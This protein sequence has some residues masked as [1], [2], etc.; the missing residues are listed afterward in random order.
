MIGVTIAAVGRIK[1]R[2]YTDAL[3]EYA[4]RLGRFCKFNVIE[5]PESNIR[6]KSDKDIARINSEEG[7]YLLAAIKGRAVVLDLKGNELTSPEFAGI[8]SDTA[9]S[10]ISEI[11]YVIGGSYGLSDEVRARADY[12]VS[13]GK[14][15]FPHQLM[16]VVLAEQIYRAFTIIE[17]SG[18]HK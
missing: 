7:K 14:I 15:T 1:E 16:R 3:A 4:K 13:F 11:T 12:R 18:Y 2:F 10:G 17:G 9:L 8:I 6:P 5:T